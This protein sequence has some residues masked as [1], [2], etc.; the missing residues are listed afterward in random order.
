LTRDALDELLTLAVDTATQQRSVALLR[1]GRVLSAVTCDAFDGGSA[2]VLG[3]IERALEQAAVRLDDVGLFACAAGPGSFTGLRAGIATV[4]ALSMTLEKPVVGVQ[5]LHALAHAARPA[6]RLVAMIPAGRGE[7]FAQ[8]LSADTGGEIEERERPSHVS[9]ARLIERIARLGGSAKWAGGGADKF[10][11]LI[12][13]VAGASGLEFR[14]AEGE[15]CVA[16]QGEWVVE[17][18]RD[19]L[20][21]SVA[22]IARAKFSRGEGEGA[23]GLRAIY[24]RPSDA[25]LNQQCH[26]PG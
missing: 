12:R 7:V 6:E 19:A 8:I 1:G 22:A 20:A 14:V 18:L 10:M 13:D 4:K 26:A 11:E 17:P 24:V 3:D 15:S 25:E 23:E 21:L 16:V 2:N 5:T 9:P